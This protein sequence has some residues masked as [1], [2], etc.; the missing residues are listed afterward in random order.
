LN[1]GS[2]E[3]HDKVIKLRSEINWYSHKLSEEQLRGPEA[4]HKVMADLQAAIRKRENEVLRLVREMSVTEAVSAGLST[5]TTATFAEIRESMTADST[6]VEY[7]Q[8]KDR[9][10]AAI[11]TQESFEIAEV[12]E[13]NLVAPLIEKL[14]F[15]LAKFR[16]GAEYANTFADSLLNTTLQHLRELYEKLFVP[17]EGL[18]KGRHLVVVPHGVLHRL[19][20]QALFDGTNYLIDKFTISYAP[21][22]TVHSLCHRR[23]VNSR[24]C[25][26]VMGVPDAAAPLIGDEA[27]AIAGI[28]PDAE[29]FLGKNATTDVLWRKG[30][31]CRLIHIAT[32]GYF[33]QDSP[34][35]SGIRLGDSVLTLMDLYRM[36]LPA[37]LVTLSG[38][39]TGAN[40][41]AG[42]DELLGLVRGLV[43]AGARATL[44]SLWDVHDRST[45]EFMTLFYGHLAAGA[46]K[47]IALQKAA[48]RVREGYPH[49]Y[50]W[51]AFSL[52]GNV[53]S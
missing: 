46:S 38:C 10:L 14:H 40:A 12:T 11:L 15:Q 52:V 33:R 16:M 27:T 1:P 32:H 39:A 42:G 47:A 26:L 37:E 51:A 19:P 50:Y 24:G 17:V 5:A 28:I 8:I 13:V 34:L 6:L 44:L 2:D 48:Q 23:P 21:S 36:K 43:Y 53:A 31:D 20:F 30:A 9:L 29:L 4:S 22:A 18:V 49:P 7:F 3:N 35:F 45:L 25:A 41:V